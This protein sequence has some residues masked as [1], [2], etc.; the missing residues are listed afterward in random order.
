MQSVR[1]GTEIIIYNI[2]GPNHYM[3]KEVCWSTLQEDMEKEENLNY[4]IGGDLNLILHAK[5]KRGGNFTTD[6][7]QEKLEN[8][9]VEHY[10]VDIVPKNRCFTW[11]N[12]ILGPGNIME[13]LDH[14]I[15]VVLL[16]S[17][18]STATSTIIDCI[19]SDHQPIT[20]DLGSHPNLGPLP[21]RFN[22]LWIDS[23]EARNILEHTWR[24]HVKGSPMHIWETKVKN[25]HNALKIWVKNSYKELEHSKQELKRK[26]SE[27][28]KDNNR[29]E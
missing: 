8:I 6:P 9:M 24:Q 23:L 16:I 11:S 12:K 28:Q 15:V 18:H 5:E 7:S 26:L 29:K 25:V 1:E 19:A 14:F 10:L 2:Y 4:I 27:I 21:F 22:T 17:L 13:R 3:D 20:L